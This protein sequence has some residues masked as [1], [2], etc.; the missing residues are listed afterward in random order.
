MRDIIR[1]RVKTKTGEIEIEGNQ[2]FI[3]KKMEQLPNL[4]KKMDHVLAETNSANKKTTALES[5]VNKAN[6][7]PKITKPVS[8][9][10]STNVTINL[11]VPNSFKQ[12]FG[13]FQDKIRQADA[14]LISSYYVQHR[15]TDNVFKCFLAK[16]TLEKS[17]IT[18]T[19]L[20]ASITRL[21][22][23]QLVQ[24]SKKTGKLTLYKVSAKG[25]RHLADLMK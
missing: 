15:S 12:W 17:G 1:I 22:N 19:N 5:N 6:Q 25:R 11:S 9:K 4:I 18:L 21:I 16:N 20:E 7:T 3:D 24:I 2:L 10:T 23:E 14:L 13:K 8:S